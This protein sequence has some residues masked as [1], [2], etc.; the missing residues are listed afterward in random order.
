[1]LYKVA[2]LSLCPR[3]GQR[4]KIVLPDGSETEEFGSHDQGIAEVA[5]LHA[6]GLIEADEAKFLREQIYAAPL[7]GIDFSSSD[8]AQ[9][10][11]DNAA[12]EKRTLH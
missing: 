10:I 6:F 12:E 1:M 7:I 4:G 3:C 5:R 11:D 2:Y 9:G 8:D